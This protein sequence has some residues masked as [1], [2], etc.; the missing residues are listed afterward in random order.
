MNLKRFSTILIGSA[1][2]AILQDAAS[3]SL[4]TEPAYA[5][6][7][8]P[9]SANIS[10][11]D[12]DNHQPELS[13]KFPW[14]AIGRLEWQHQGQS[15]R[16]CKAMLIGTDTVLSNAHC[17]LLPNDEQ[18]GKRKDVFMDT[19][20]YAALKNSK[21]AAPQLIFKPGAFDWITLDESAIVRYRTGWTVHYQA[22][23][24]DW[25]LLILDSPLGEKYGYLDWQHIELSDD[26][27]SA[28]LALS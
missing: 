20:R 21:D 10:I 9:A 8:E 27:I 18:S 11:V 24:E 16:S 2:A 28:I 23:A 7:A 4:N 3:Q 12:Q 22:P 15:V 5:L 17:L 6:E 25:A 19:A 13:Q 14:L 1:I 26:A